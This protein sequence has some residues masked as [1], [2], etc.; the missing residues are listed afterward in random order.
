[1]I[2]ESFVL[3]TDL[4]F[5]EVDEGIIVYDR[6]VNKTYCFYGP[7]AWIVQQLASGASPCLVREQGRYR[8]DWQ[9]SNE[10]IDF[11]LQ[12]LSEKGLLSRIHSIQ[13]SARDCSRSIFH[14]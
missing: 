11:A 14:S 2:S 1:M 8:Y 13:I 3:K 6:E 10:L 7:F 9:N 12:N 4:I 5:Q